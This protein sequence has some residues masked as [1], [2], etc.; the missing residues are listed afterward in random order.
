MRLVWCYIFS[1]LLYGC[2]CWTVDPITERRIEAFEIVCISLHASYLMYSPSYKNRSINNNVKVKKK[3]KS[4]L[5]PLK[6]DI[7]LH[8][9]YNEINPRPNIDV[10][11]FKRVLKNHEEP[12][13]LAIT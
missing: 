6:R 4:Y 7:H 3:V 11:L 5:T 10:E 8:R 13:R 9:P 1:E 2:K 12:V